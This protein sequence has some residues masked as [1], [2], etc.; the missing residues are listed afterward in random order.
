MNL[1]Y[2]KL[3]TAVK[4]LCENVSAL[5]IKAKLELILMVPEPSM[6]TSVM[7]CLKNSR[8]DSVEDPSEMYPI[9]ENFTKRIKSN[10]IAR[11]NILKYYRT[12]KNDSLEE[13]DYF[14]LFLLYSAGEKRF[15]LQY[16]FKGNRKFPSQSLLSST[17]NIIKL[18]PKFCHEMCSLLER[19]ACDAKEALEGEQIKWMFVSILRGLKCID[20]CPIQEVECIISS[21]VRLIERYPS[22]ASDIG[23]FCLSHIARK[24]PELAETSLHSI[25]ILWEYLEVFD[26]TN[27]RCLFEI[28]VRLLQ[29]TNLSNTETSSLSSLA[30]LLQKD[31]CHI[32]ERHRKVGVVGA[33]ANIELIPSLFLDRESNSDTNFS[34]TPCFFKAVNSQ[35]LRELS[36]FVSCDLFSVETVD[37]ILASALELFQRHFYV[38]RRHSKHDEGSLDDLSSSCEELDQGSVT[39]FHMKSA[40]IDLWTA[41]ELY[42]LIAKCSCYQRIEA[43]AL[44]Y[45]ISILCFDT[46]Q[47]PISED[48][49]KHG[50]FAAGF[51]RISINELVNNSE[52]VRFHF[53]ELR[54]LVQHLLQLEE[55]L[56][57]CCNEE[58]TV[59]VIWKQFARDYSIQNSYDY[60]S[61]L[62]RFSVDIVYRF[63]QAVIQA[64]LGEKMDTLIACFYCFLCEHC[65]DSE[66]S[67]QHHYHQAVYEGSCLCWRYHSGTLCL[68]TL[69]TLLTDMDVP[70]PPEN[71]VLMKTLHLA[72]EACSYELK[73]ASAAQLLLSN[74]DICLRSLA[75]SNLQQ[76][77][78]VDALHHSGVVR[79]E[80]FYHQ[81]FSLFMK[82]WKQAE[83][84]CL[85][86]FTDLL[87]ILWRLQHS[88][89]YSESCPEMESIIQLLEDRNWVYSL[90]LELKCDVTEVLL[91]HSRNEFFRVLSHSS[92]LLQAPSSCHL[93]SAL[94]KVVVSIERQKLKEILLKLSLEHLEMEIKKF[95]DSDLSMQPSQQDWMETLKIFSLV[96][97][98]FRQ[99]LQEAKDNTS[100][101]YLRF[102]L[103]WGKKLTALILDGGLQLLTK[104]LIQNKTSAIRLFKELQKCTRA[105]HQICLF[106]K[107]TKQESLLLLLPT[108]KK[109]LEML[110][111]RVKELLQQQ[112][113]AHLFWLGNLKNK[114][115]QGE[116]LPSQINTSED[117]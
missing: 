63:C 83:P 94:G 101:K 75:E 14:L 23:L 107:E 89:D 85:A 76:H 111:F 113:V 84:S 50:L 114:N 37:R 100:F 54:Y 13:L 31:L 98:T 88:K 38:E 102:C 35:V 90:T 105:I 47:E 72:C 82:V 95:Q 42:R 49:L 61:F 41:Y 60:R 16:V 29:R 28:F 46:G 68:A 12:L 79:I 1:S 5:G 62:P 93:V 96:F 6:M 45:V 81:V 78:S 67:S 27:L 115:L 69:L 109:Q 103:K 116:A 80:Q 33:C 74:D 117:T 25:Q 86:A 91:K 15:V 48:T 8:V 9:M 17:Y 7:S 21:L 19:A 106:C 3:S 30:I 2:G 4:Q 70:H 11:K 24:Y 59:D 108:V 99:V 77:H 32:D 73:D 44:A 104:E 40:D 39:T 112:G 110:V 18:Y 71:P 64:E 53:K 55:F 92:D 22:F 20:N 51:A 58:S 65:S 87:N 26:E 66:S 52:L 56:S 43:N 36:Y 97:G 10:A 34:L 57:S